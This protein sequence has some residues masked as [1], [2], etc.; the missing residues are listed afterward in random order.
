MKAGILLKVVHWLL[1]VVA[2]ALVISGLGITEFRV[3]EA[4]TF[5]M[6]S[7]ALSFQLHTILWIP[8][9]VLLAFQQYYLPR[10]VY[11]F[12]PDRL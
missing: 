7:K 12:A 3:V 6:L 11:T 5:G 4:I 2:I 9:L 8:F 1:A 10:V